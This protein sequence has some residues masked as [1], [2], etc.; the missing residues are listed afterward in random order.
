MAEEEKAPA[1]APRSPRGGNNN[2]A[3]S[4]RSPRNRTGWR[5]RRRWWGGRGPRRYYYGNPYPVYVTA[6]EPESTPPQSTG[7]PEFVWFI[8]GAL[9]VIALVFGIRVLD[10]NNKRPQRYERSIMV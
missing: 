9:I 7:M 6:P 1:E 4:P 10:S 8:F 2:T 3:R 5:G